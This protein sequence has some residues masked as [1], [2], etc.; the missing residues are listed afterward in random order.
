[1][2]SSGTKKILIVDDSEETRRLIGR[3][4][5]MQG[6]PILEASNGR[7]AIE[8]AQREIPDLILMDVNLPVMGGIDA[9]RHIRQQPENQDTIILACTDDISGDYYR[10]EALEAG[11]TDYIT[12]PFTLDE[13]EELVTQYFPI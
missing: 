11:C 1:M 7:E 8:V 9:T 12:K 3:V 6:Y 10:T 4:L 13:I 2:Q 5:S